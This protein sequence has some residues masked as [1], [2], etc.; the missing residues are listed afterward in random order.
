MYGNLFV[1]TGPRGLRYTGEI[2]QSTLKGNI[3]VK[4]SSLIFPPAQQTANEELSN[5]VPVQFVNDTMHTA[6]SKEHPIASSYFDVEDSAE[7]EGT[8]REQLPQK[9]FVDG[10]HYDLD[11]ECAG[12]STEIK[13]IF[14]SAT[15]E[16]LDANINGRFSIS[17]DGKRWV[18]ALTIER[19]Y[20]RF[21]KQ[22]SAE[23][24]IRYS[25]NFL[26]PELDITAKYEGFRADSTSSHP[27][28]VVVSM[29]ITGTRLSP[30]LEWS[31]TIDDVDYANYR[32]PKSSDVQTDALSFILAGTF[33]LSRSEANNVASDLRPTAYSSLLTGGSQQSFNEAV[34]LRLSGVAWNGYWKYDGRLLTGQFGAANIS[35]LY[36]F[37]DIFDNPSLRNFM[38]ELERKVEPAS[39]GDSPE[40][41]QTNS[42]RLY[43][44]FSF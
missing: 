7:V 4:N 17:E 12:G 41:K 37:G 35:L 11:I 20:Y 18:G 44:R 25:G 5:T 43:Y 2:E 9:S 34:S 28:K 27:E 42:A 6:P 38:F 39:I 1:Q 23:G 40:T 31:M 29:T 32:G 16:E 8:N 26:N 19:A 13:M 15:G 22:F 24:T 36:S 14:N 10:I 33:P 21:I 30:K 3:L